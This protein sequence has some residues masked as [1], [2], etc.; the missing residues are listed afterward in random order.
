[1]NVEKG[2]ERGRGLVNVEKGRERERS[3]ECRE[4]EGEV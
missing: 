2:R 1:M 4:R 3:S